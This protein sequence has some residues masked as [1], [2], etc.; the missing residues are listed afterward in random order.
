MT[1][2]QL[3]PEPR[4]TVDDELAALAARAFGRAA[5]AEPIDGNAVRLLLDAEEN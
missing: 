3:E 2:M 4:A 5:G 1:R